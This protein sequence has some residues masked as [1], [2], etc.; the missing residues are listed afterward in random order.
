MIEDQIGS[1]ECCLFTTEHREKPL[2]QATKEKNSAKTVYSTKIVHTYVAD[3]WLLSDDSRST[4]W[5]SKRDCTTCQELGC[6]AC[7][8][9]GGEVVFGIFG[10]GCEL[11]LQTLT[12]FQ[13]KI[14]SSPIPGFSLC[15]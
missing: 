10:W 6:T 1:Y 12:L 13:S 2:D 3:Y 9:G 7:M 4:Q 15:L 5:H 14:C 11:V 8:V